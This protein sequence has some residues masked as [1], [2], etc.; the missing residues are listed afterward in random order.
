MTNLTPVREEPGRRVAIDTSVVVPAYNEDEGLPV[1][2][3]KL[4][5]AVD[6][7][8]EVV[9]VDDGSTDETRAVAARYPVRVISHERNRGKA[10]AMRTG[11]RAAAGDAVIFIDADDTYPAELVARMADALREHDMVVGSRVGGHANIPAFNRIGNALFR[12]SIRYLYGFK[13]YDP[14]TGFYGLKKAHLERMQL[15]SEGFRIE[16]EIAIKAARM[17]ISIVDLPIDYGPRLGQAKLRGLQDG[18]AIFQ[19]I[20]GLLPV[21]NPALVF[22]WPGLLM[23]IAGFAAALLLASGDIDAAGLRFGPRAEISAAFAGLLGLQAALTGLG[24]SAYNT[25]HRYVRPGIFSRSLSPAAYFGASLACVLLGAVFAIGADGARE[26]V[27]AAFVIVAGAQIAL[28]GLFI[29]TIA[30]R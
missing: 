28:A 4:L 26:F 9:V 8:T 23:A 5:G 22:F 30:G 3:E 10:E 13:A 16:A 25:L 2:L 11:I 21:Y 19:T 1:V 6:E 27:P 24:L 14:L 12:H 18:Y 15:Q 7:A 29:S 17:G 20:L